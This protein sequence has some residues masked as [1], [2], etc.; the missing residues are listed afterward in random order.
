LAV[1]A[2]ESPD[3]SGG[4]L[5][6]TIE[7]DGI[8]LTEGAATFNG[9][10]SKVKFGDNGWCYIKANL[11]EG[12]SIRITGELDSNGNALST[13]GLFRGQAYYVLE[14]DPYD[15]RP[16]GYVYVGANPDQVDPR[17]DYNATSGLWYKQENV[18][19]DPQ[20]DLALPDGTSKSLSIYALFIQS[21]KENT[22]VT[23][24]GRYTTGNDTIFVVNTLDKNKVSPTGILIDNLPYLLMIGIPVAVFIALFALKR[25]RNAVE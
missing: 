3:A 20:D 12:S 6:Y 10:I 7:G 17:K 11:K 1:K 2:S 5:T 8:D 19:N 22:Q 25:R 16:T 18:G 13:N 21:S 14:N 15:Y 23:T 24:T 9:Q 4:Y